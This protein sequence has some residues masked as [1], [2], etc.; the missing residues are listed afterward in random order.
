[1]SD[2]F[3][4]SFIRGNESTINWISA[5]VPIILA[6]R[7]NMPYHSRFYLIENVISPHFHDVIARAKDSV[8]KTLT[9]W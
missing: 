3:Q 7:S 8:I 9:K 4:V 5:N 2:P 1:M 6:D